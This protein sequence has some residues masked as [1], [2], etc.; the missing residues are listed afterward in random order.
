[1]A[2]LNLPAS[3]AVYVDADCII[4]AVEKIAPYDAVQGSAKLRRSCK[5]PLC[6]LLRVPEAAD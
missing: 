1:M 3:G 5:A 4:Y 2:A 6:R